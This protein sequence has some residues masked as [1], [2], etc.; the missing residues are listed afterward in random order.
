MQSWYPEQFERDMATTEAE[1]LAALPRAVGE[2]PCA[3]HASRAE[4]TLHEGRLLLHWHALP[5]RVIALL[6]LQ[7]LAVTFAFEGVDEAARQRFMKRF[8]LT[9]QRGGG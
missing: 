7:R 3:V 8:D 2:H 4:I 5:P 6:R 9:M 1:W